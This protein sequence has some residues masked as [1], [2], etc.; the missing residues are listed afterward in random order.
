[1]DPGLY[2]EQALS[3]PL[4]TWRYMDDPDD[5]YLGVITQDVPD[6]VVVLDNG[7]QIDLYTYASMAIAASQVQQAEIN[8]LRAM[9]EQLSAECAR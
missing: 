2:A 4:A 6:S 9:V 8:E 5:V 1:V 7:D 3:M